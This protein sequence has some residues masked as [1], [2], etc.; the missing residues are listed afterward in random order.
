MD[1]TEYGNLSAGTFHISHRWEI[2]LRS[3]K[4]F[5]SLWEINV[6]NAH[7]TKQQSYS[8]LGRLEV[9]FQ[10]FWQHYA[11]VAPLDSAGSVLFLLSL[12]T[13][14]QQNNIIH[15]VGTCKIPLPTARACGP[16]PQIKFSVDVEK[17]LRDIPRIFTQVKWGRDNCLSE[18][19]N[20]ES[21]HVCMHSGS[22]IILQLQTNT[23]RCYQWKQL[24]K[25]WL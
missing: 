18:S 13:A 23:S 24:L 9:L 15:C 12:P 16:F 1:I 14:E 7:Q 17:I 5:I 21:V 25:D 6:V 3:Y 4:I 11:E 2:A 8:H 20:S 19:A 10:L 22:P